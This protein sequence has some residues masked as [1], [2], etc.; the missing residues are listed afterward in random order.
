MDLESNGDLRLQIT[1][2]KE[3]SQDT[4]GVIWET[5]TNSAYGKWRLSNG[6]INY[7]FN[8]SKSAIDSFFIQTDWFDNFHDKPLLSFSKKLD[9]AFIYSLPCILTECETV[10]LNTTNRD[11]DSLKV[12]F[13][14]GVVF[15]TTAILVHGKVIDRDSK[16]SIENASITLQYGD[17][18]YFTKTDK[19]GEFEFLK[20]IPQGAWSIKIV[21]PQYKCLIVNDVVQYGGQWIN[22][23]IQQ[24]DKF[25]N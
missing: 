1:T 25:S 2:S 14:K 9:T 15:D 5:M 6:F 10:I 20:N 21:H 13:I 18:Q 24:E 4:T 8:D 7:S 22:F 17:I 11:I 23:K 16:I 19:N 3:V 12:R